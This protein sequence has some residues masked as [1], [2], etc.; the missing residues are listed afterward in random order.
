MENPWSD[1]CFE[2]PYILQ[3]DKRQILDFDSRQKSRAKLVFESIPEPFIGNPDTARIVLLLLNP[4]HSDQDPAA[5]RNMHFKAALLKNLRGEPQDYPFYPLN[6]AFAGNP[7]AKWWIP[8]VRELQQASGLNLKTL[9]ERLLAIE[10]F[11]Y[12]SRS[13]GLPTTQVC[14]S[15]EYTFQLARKMMDD[16][17]VLR[18]RSANRWSIVDTRF[19]HVPTLKNPRCGYISRR[20]TGHDVFERLVRALG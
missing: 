19:Q 6:P 16:R 9:S 17:V 7:T 4:G 13:S 3:M 11:P 5:H 1:I 2:S 14:S 12:H 8:R 15:Q 10:W 20:N 18:M